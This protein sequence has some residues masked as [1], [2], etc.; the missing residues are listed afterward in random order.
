MESGITRLTAALTAGASPFATGSATVAAIMSMACRTSCL[1]AA[2]PGLKGSS[3]AEHPPSTP[4]PSR[5]SQVRICRDVLRRCPSLMS[6]P[7]YGKSVFSPGARGAHRT[8]GG[9]DRVRSPPGGAEAEGVNGMDMFPGACTPQKNEKQRCEQPPVTSPHR[10]I[11]I[12]PEEITC[13]G[14]TDEH[15]QWPP[16]DPG[17]PPV[18]F[19]NHP[20]CRYPRL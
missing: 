4:S 1:K 10:S 8:A 15:T 19:S 20:C 6:A 3:W 17:P 18:R 7:R 14:E 2:A 13:A 9:A 5:A 12:L 16:P 11:S